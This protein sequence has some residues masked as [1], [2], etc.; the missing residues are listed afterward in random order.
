MNSHFFAIMIE[1][2]FRVSVGLDVLIWQYYT[3]AEVLIPPVSQGA[4]PGGGGLLLFSVVADA[5]NSHLDTPARR[6]VYLSRHVS[7][8]VISKFAL[9]LDIYLSLSLIWRYC[10]CLVFQ[11]AASMVGS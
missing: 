2:T 9:V 4:V 5:D 1:L 7:I 8:P 11:G 6:A 10:Y 3:G